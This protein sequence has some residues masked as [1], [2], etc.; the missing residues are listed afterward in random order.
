MRHPQK[1]SC[2]FKR[3]V[4]RV[5][6]FS[7]TVAGKRTVPE[8]PITPAVTCLP[9]FPLRLSL[10]ASLSWRDHE[11]A[12]A[13]NRDEDVFVLRISS[14]RMAPQRNISNKLLGGGIHHGQF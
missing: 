1:Q 3:C 12:L 8:I 10:V 5:A 11:D 2:S 13:G 14:N 6:Y 9:G 7:S 4:T